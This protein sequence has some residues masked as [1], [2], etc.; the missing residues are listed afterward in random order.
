M[1]LAT[2]PIQRRKRAR[3]SKPLPEIDV[4]CMIADVLMMTLKPGWIW[5]HTPNGGERPAF[6]NA[7]GKRVSI[8]AARLKRMGVK[9]G[10]SDFLL[11][12][13]TGELCALELKREGMS[14]TVDQT[15][16]LVAVRM[17]GHRS[18]WV[19]NFDDAIKVLQSWGCL[20][21]TP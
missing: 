20:R 3:A 13:P 19:D 17:A 2:Q 14:P 6:I 8:E 15:D 5:W 11:L 16:F 1:T 4:H 9:P 21:I 18:A 12:S 10:I 7:K